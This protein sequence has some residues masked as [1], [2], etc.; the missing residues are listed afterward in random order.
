MFIVILIIQNRQQL[1]LLVAQEDL[2]DWEV[3]LMFLVLAEL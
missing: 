3:L 2:W 1:I